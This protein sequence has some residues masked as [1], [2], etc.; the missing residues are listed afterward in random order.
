MPARLDKRLRVLEILYYAMWR[1]WSNPSSINNESGL[2]E[3]R[4]LHAADQR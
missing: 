2:V 3:Y 1:T 4:L